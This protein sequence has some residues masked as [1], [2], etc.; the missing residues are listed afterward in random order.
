MGMVSVNTYGSFRPHRGRT[1]SAMH[2]GHAKAVA[3]AIAFLANTVMPEAIALDHELHEE[4]E[5]PEIGFGM[6]D[7]FHP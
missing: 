1:F 2:G 5:K 4:G 7:T 6:G 3:E